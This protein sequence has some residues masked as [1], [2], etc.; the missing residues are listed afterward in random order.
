MV[1]P[2]LNYKGFYGEINYS[3]ADGVMFGTI[4]GIDDIISYEGENIAELKKDFEEEVDDYIEYC[5]ERGKVLRKPEC[6]YN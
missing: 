4:W 3:E 1:C 6:G 5:K 2:K